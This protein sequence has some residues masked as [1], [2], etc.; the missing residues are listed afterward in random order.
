[1]HKL[2]DDSFKLDFIK[3][4]LLLVFTILVVYFSPN[5]ISQFIFV[6]FLAMFYNSK[7]DFFW[8]AF[9]FV[10]Y[11][12]PNGFFSGELLSEFQRIPVYNLGG[13]LALDFYDFFFLAVFLK[14]LFRKRWKK[15]IFSRPLLIIFGFLI[16]SYFY[17]MVLG[18]TLS[19]HFSTMRNWLPF[20]L[21]LCLPSLMDEEQDYFKFMYLLFPMVLFVLLGQIFEIIFNVKLASLLVGNASLIAS[22]SDIPEYE[23]LIRVV[24]AS[25]LSFFCLLFSLIILNLKNRKYNKIYIYI[26]LSASLFSIYLSATR[27]WIIAFMIILLLHFLFVERNLSSVLGKIGSIAILIM[28]LMQFFPVLRKQTG[29]VTDRLLTMQSLMKGDVTAQG[30]LS[31]L[32]VRGPKIMK[33]YWEKP[34][35]GWGVSFES[36]RNWDGHVGNQSLLM[37]GGIIGFMIFMYYFYSLIKISLRVEKRVSRNNMYKNTLYILSIVLFGLFIIHS[38]SAQMFGLIAKQRTNFMLAIFFVTFDFF[39]KTLLSKEKELRSL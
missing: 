24:N 11:V 14:I 9:V 29:N 20:V 10:L 33:F 3:F 21:F 30:T 19:S 39:I 35:L 32:D 17:S 13:K 38:T 26:V 18:M 36:Y 8:I 27:G 22:L 7:K 6:V 37:Q 12:E 1:M 4:N 5:L 28:L 23:G 2:L 15:L 25:Y 16:V 31:R 34:I